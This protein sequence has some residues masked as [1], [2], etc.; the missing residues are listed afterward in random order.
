M[1]S[2][3]GFVPLST[4]ARAS[5]SDQGN[6]RQSDETRASK[7]LSVSRYSS[8]S[9]L[10]MSFPSVCFCCHSSASPAFEAKVKTAREVALALSI[11]IFCLTPD[12]C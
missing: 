2:M 11:S 5:S 12:G 9:S 8:A 10:V 7:L 3:K 4:K 1:G 6:F